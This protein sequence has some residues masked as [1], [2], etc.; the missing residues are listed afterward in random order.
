M[1]TLTSKFRYLLD[2]YSDRSEDKVHA[3]TKFKAV[4]ISYL[5]LIFGLSALSCFQEKTWAVAGLVIGSVYVL[6][7]MYYFY[8]NIL[9]PYLKEVDVRDRLPES[10]WFSQKPDIRAW[11]VEWV[12][13]TL[14][15]QLFIVL[16]FWIT[17]NN[18]PFRK[19]MYTHPYMYGLMYKNWLDKKEEMSVDGYLKVKK[20]ESD[21]ATQN[22][23][24]KAS[25]GKD[26][27]KTDD[28]PMIDESVNKIPFL[29]AFSFG[30]LGTI[31]YTL[32]DI[33]Y[34]AHTTDLY[35]KTLNSYAIRFIFVPSLCI[36][37]A[38][39]Q[40]ND[41]WTNLAPPIFF[42]IG[43]FPQAA[44]QYMEEK[45]MSYFNLKKDQERE[46]LPLNLIQGMTDY[47]T[48]RFKEIGIGDVQ[49]LAYTDLSYV[50]KNIGYCERLLC[51]FVS[52]A[53][54]I[55]HL[56]E[57][58]KRLRAYGIRDVISFK[59]RINRAN[60]SHV[61]ERINID[62]EILGSF[63]DLIESDEIRGRMQNLKNVLHECERREHVA[64]A[65]G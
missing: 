7:T 34:R 51:D 27:P 46:E 49:N 11:M 26:E 36:V 21:S 45:A 33:T 53:F 18:N 57:N 61:A 31:I 47:V 9:T 1:N 41:W 16:G 56:K 10:S 3:K 37:I 42:L 30:F 63:L 43:F 54:F 59:S 50:C 6:I 13:P 39:F 24:N 25:G 48:Y 38:H 14:M 29:I 58:T 22:K 40:A 4:F 35:P 19:S 8:E 20:L 64:G 32:K 2:V 62:S 12:L 23:D 65:S 28:S 60:Y 44:L 52:Q 55:L 5:V 15:I 17:L